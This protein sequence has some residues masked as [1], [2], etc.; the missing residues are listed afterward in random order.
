MKFSQGR[1]AKIQ[2]LYAKW[3]KHATKKSAVTATPG[4]TPVVIT[5]PVATSDVVIEPV[6]SPAVVVTEPVASP[7]VVVDT[8]T[9]ASPAVVDETASIASMPV[10]EV[11]VEL[12]SGKDTEPVEVVSVEFPPPTEDDTVKA[13]ANT[14][15][16]EFPLVAPTKMSHT[17]VDIRGEVPTTTHAKLL[18]DQIA[19]LN[20]QLV[21]SESRHALILEAKARATHAFLQEQTAGKN[22]REAQSPKA[23]MQIAHFLASAHSYRVPVHMVGQDSMIGKIPIQLPHDQYAMVTGVE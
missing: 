19:V 12:V 6:A 1:F 4:A 14:G 10:E 13:V 9:V 7:D 21:E 22:M 18:K 20:A 16:G 5:A 11:T 8:P 2:S 3:C 15:A 23:M 17:V